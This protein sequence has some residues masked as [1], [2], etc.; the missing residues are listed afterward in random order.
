MKIEKYRV[1]KSP[2]A[3]HVK[4]PWV[5]LAVGAD[6]IEC[7]ESAGARRGFFRTKRD[8]VAALAYA[9]AHE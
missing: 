4:A 9:E 7:E 2:M 3:E 8:A 5:I 1:A 6:L